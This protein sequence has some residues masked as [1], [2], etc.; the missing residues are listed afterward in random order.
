MR[1][2]T[3]TTQLNTRRAVPIQLMLVELF[4][5]Q[6]DNILSCGRMWKARLKVR[7]VNGGAGLNLV[8]GV[9]DIICEAPY[10]VKPWHH[11]QKLGRHLR[12][13]SAKPRVLL[14]A[15]PAGPPR[16]HVPKTGPA[17]WESALATP[18]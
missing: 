9:M 15:G 2:S 5:D 3:Q 11:V 13:R 18:D 16:E 6:Y 8:Y 1:K 4:D 17:G 14:G 10:E 7:E 12:Q